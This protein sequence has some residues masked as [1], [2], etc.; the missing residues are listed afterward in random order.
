LRCEA[1]GIGH[2]D[3]FGYNGGCPDINGKAKYFIF[4]IRLLGVKSRPNPIL[5]IN[6]VLENFLLKK[7]EFRGNCY[8][9]VFLY[10]ILTCQDLFGVR[11]NFYKAIIPACPAAS[12]TVAPA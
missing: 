10:T 8:R 4:C 1:T 12:V 7:S 5:Y 9:E 6:S 2:I 3:K 11:V